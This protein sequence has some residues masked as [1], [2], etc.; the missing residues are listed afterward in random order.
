MRFR[1]EKKNPSGGIN[2]LDGRPDHPAQTRDVPLQAYQAPDSECKGQGVVALQLDGTQV[3]ARDPAVIT[4]CG[5]I[6][7]EGSPNVSALLAWHTTVERPTWATTVS[8]CHAASVRSGVCRS[9]RDI[10]GIAGGFCRP[11]PDRSTEVSG[12]PTM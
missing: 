4:T 12:I 9:D 5:L 1:R 2:H 10:H 6:P 8:A 3:L 7:I 11:D